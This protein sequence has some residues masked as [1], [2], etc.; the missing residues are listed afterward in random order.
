M[1]TL[2]WTQNIFY[3][4]LIVR[5]LSR[6]IC[7]SW[8][9][10]AEFLWMASMTETKE[11]RE[12]ACVGEK[13]WE[14]WTENSRSLL[15]SAVYNA[16]RICTTASLRQMEQIWVHLCQS[17]FAY[18]SFLTSQSVWVLLMIMNPTHKYVAMSGF[19]FMIEVE[20]SGNFVC[21]S[22]YYS[23]SFTLVLSTCR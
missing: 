18:S 9:M 10:R 16:I 8:H 7:M 5:C 19:Y 2:V 11:E 4:E 3:P 14:K 1:P 12:S 21:N 17:L 22:F 6:K 15:C 20:I 13:C 23:Y